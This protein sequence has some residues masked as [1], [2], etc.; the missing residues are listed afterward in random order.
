MAATLDGNTV[1]VKSVAFSP[2]GALLAAGLFDGSLELWDPS[3]D[4]VL[5]KLTGHTNAVS[6][7]AFSPDGS[8][9]ASS[10]YDGTI[11]IWG[12]TP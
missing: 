7:L 10:S 6:G 3:T 8:T 4:E 9:L 1:G 11:R 12:V 5:N 2:D